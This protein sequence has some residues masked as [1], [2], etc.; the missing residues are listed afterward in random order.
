VPRGEIGGR[1]FLVASC[2]VGPL[3]GEILREEPLVDGGVGVRRG[4]VQLLLEPED[5]RAVVDRGGAA[6]LA[7]RGKGR[8]N[9]EEAERASSRG[10]RRAVHR[11]SS[12]RER[13]SSSA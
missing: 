9:R 6:A 7:G 8:E 3:A 12:F 10:C 13:E 4:V 1:L 2:P 11:S 5:R